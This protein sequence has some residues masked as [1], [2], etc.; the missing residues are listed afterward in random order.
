MA[1]YLKMSSLPT[2]YIPQHKV[3]SASS[4]GLLGLIA[5]VMVDSGLRWPILKSDLLSI[6]DRMIPPSG[7]D[8]FQ[9]H[10]WKASPGEVMTVENLFYLQHSSIN[11]HL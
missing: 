5:C 7:Q 4:S 11:L 1:K 10:S 3:T 6:T 8:Q 2:G 9:A